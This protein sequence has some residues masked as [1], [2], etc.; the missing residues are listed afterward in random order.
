MCNII[1]NYILYGLQSIAKDWHIFKYYLSSTLNN[2]YPHLKELLCENI[3][4]HQRLEPQL[5]K[6]T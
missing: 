4:V 2:Y 5:T 3:T 1:E 6:R